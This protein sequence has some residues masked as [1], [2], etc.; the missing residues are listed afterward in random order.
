MA[1]LQVIFAG[2]CS[3]AAVLSVQFFVLTTDRLLLLFGALI[4]AGALVQLPLETV[5]Q[6]APSIAAF[7][8]AQTGFAW[9]VRYAPVSD[10][11][12]FWLG[13]AAAGVLSVAALAAVLL[14]AGAIARALFECGV[15]VQA[16]CLAFGLALRYAELDPLTGVKSRRIFDRQL[17]ASWKRAKR[18][19]SGLA[20]LL[21]SADGVRRYEAERGRLAADALLRRVASLCRGC[22]PGRADLFA[23]YGD[24]SFAA[25]VPRVT[26]AQAD[27]IG[28]HMRQVVSEGCLLPIGVGVSSIENAISHEALLQQAAR[29]SAR[30]AI[31]SGL[32]A[33]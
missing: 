16:A 32:L 5:F 11:R 31:T 24:E 10:R 12:V 13:Y 29:R 28:A 17:V 7:L 1:P 25:I 15:L 14:H 9:A 2:F 30:E 19:G 33:R 22:C 21:I 27:E 26:R 8:G 6:L 20:V 23:R 4:A 3:A 18:E